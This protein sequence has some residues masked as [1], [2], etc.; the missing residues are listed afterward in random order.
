M[1]NM[2]WNIG[3]FNSKEVISNWSQ[4]VLNILD[5]NII[6]HGL[7]ERTQKYDALNLEKQF[8]EPY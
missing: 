2:V 6:F 7:Q 4:A 1:V 5:E 8:M 3:S